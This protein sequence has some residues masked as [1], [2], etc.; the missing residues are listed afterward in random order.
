MIK[1][2]KKILITVLCRLIFSCNQREKSN[3]EDLMIVKG[4]IKGL[5]KGA[6]GTKGL[7]CSMMDSC[8]SMSNLFVM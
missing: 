2:K 7:P 1:L 8:P 6:S 5:T 4:R 3:S